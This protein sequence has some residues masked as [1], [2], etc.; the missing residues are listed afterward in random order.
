MKISL[1]KLRVMWRRVRRM[2]SASAAFG[3]ALVETLMRRANPFAP[4][5]ERVDWMSDVAAWLRSGKRPARFDEN[6]WQRIRLRRARFLLDWLDSHRD[7]RR[8]VQATLRKTLREAAGPGLFCVTGLPRET[9]FLADLRVRLVGKLLPQPALQKDS[10]AL[11]AAL[12]PS[13]EDAD[14]LAC[15]DQRTL[16]RLWRLCADDGIAH[17]YRQQIDEALTYLVS[18]IVA[19]GISP[20]FRQRLEPRIPL[21]ATPFMALQREMQKYLLMSAHDEAALRSVRM[22]V[23]VCRAQ[24]DRIES[25]LD[26]HGVSVG[27]VYQ[28]ERMRAQLTRVARLIDLR[29]T[30]PDTQSTTQVRALLIDLIAAHH[31]RRSTEALFSRSFSLLARKMIERHADHGEQHA[32]RDRSRYL[33][34]LRAGCRGGVVAALIVLAVSLA[35]NAGGPRFFDG[36]LASTIYAVGFIA[37]SSL[38]GALAA[39][40]PATTT[41]LLALKLRAID[42][43]DLNEPVAETAALMRS[44]TA[45]M[46]GNLLA[47]I[48]I[49]AVMA[50]LTKFAVGEPLL[51]T[52]DALEALRDLS[53]F[54]LAPLAAAFTGVL[55]WL[56]SV[57]AGFA[58]NWF[59]LRRLRDVLAHERRL[60]AVLGAKRSGRIAGWLERHFAGIAGNLSLA[61]LFGLTPVLARFFDAPLDIQHV[62]LGAGQ[63][64][65]ANVSLG[66]SATATSEFWQALGGVF[67]SGILN[68]G[69]ALACA[70]A[71]A[72]RAAN[73]APRLRRQVFGAVLRR[74]AASPG[75]FLL[76][77]RPS[78]E[79]TI[80]PFARRSERSEQSERQRNSGSGR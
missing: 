44:Q 34:M 14:W 4:W 74:F 38:G 63:L 68:V 58:D 23:A 54:G 20:E 24:A 41:P 76:P 51:R 32:V 15:L 39:S 52:N 61:L 79:V 49:V 27:L 17:G 33:A 75:L 70:L 13:Q 48:P 10:S 1:M 77:Q 11:F 22:L 71:F 37:I 57:A 26:E 73:V 9:G 59:A 43:V 47:V 28:V 31:R 42:P 80:L 45:T 35:G 19:T 25:H 2:S 69:V 3:A 60:V 36:L 16:A 78:A 56:S 40:Q 66:W 50:V 12:F 55:L 5:R 46:A 67:L 6:T 30:L 29:A 53:M 8:T 21:L 64:I 7:V 62:T 18:M 65:A 72:L